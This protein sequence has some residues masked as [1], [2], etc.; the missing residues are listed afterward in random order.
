MQ[1]EWTRDALA[2]KLDT[3]YSIL[4]VMYYDEKSGYSNEYMVGM[5]DTLK[6]TATKAQQ[7]LRDEKKAREYVRECER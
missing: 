6:K 4:N 7:Y 1:R 2:Y 3:M 5:L